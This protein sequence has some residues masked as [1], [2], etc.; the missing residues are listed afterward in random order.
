MSPRVVHVASGREWRGGQRQVWL[1]AREL[2]RLGVSQVVVTGAGGALASRLR[3]DGVPVRAV[4]WTTGLDPRVLPAVLAELRT[5]ASLVHAHDAHA[6][7][8][9]GLAASLGGRPLV[10]T[11]RVDFHL[12][13][14]G[15]WGRAAQ[16]IAISHAVGDVLADDG[17]A[18]GSRRDRPFRHRPR[19][20]AATPKLGIR[21]RLGLRSDALIAANVAALVPHKDH[22]TLVRAAGR[23]ADRF[24]SLYWVIAGEGPERAEL[25]RL[26]AELGLDGRVHLL[27]HLD[28]P[29]RLVADADCFV[30]SSREEGLGTSV[31]EAMALGI[32]V[33]STTRGRPPRNASRRRGPVGRPGRSR[34]AGGR[35]RPTAGRARSSSRSL[36][37]R[38]GPPSAASAPRAWQRRC[39]RC[40]V[41]WSHFLDGS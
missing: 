30:M 29:A 15:C 24:P 37:T 23:L 32:P 5:G 6:V 38:P 14:R 40:I 8:L 26:R 41:P 2:E 16:I 33:A 4:S 36:V 1:L 21:A 28:E 25:E 22:A 12:R 20:C 18:P 39:D 13:R 10:A 34:R 19:G 7:T 27:G 35:G 3:G 17:V 9:G 11:R 31:L